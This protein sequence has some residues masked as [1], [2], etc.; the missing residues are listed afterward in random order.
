MQNT[1]PDGNGIIVRTAGV[2]EWGLGQ[3]A[4]CAAQ[5]YFLIWRAGLH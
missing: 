3:L 5:V 2:S 1:T 4:Q